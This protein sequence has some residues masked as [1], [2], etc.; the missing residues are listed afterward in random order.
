[1]SIAIDDTVLA[2]IISILLVIVAPMVVVC[3]IEILYKKYKVRREVNQCT[4]H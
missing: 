1:M 4:V 3:I 2:M